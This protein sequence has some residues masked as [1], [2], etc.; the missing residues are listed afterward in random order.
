MVDDYVFECPHCEL[1]VTVPRNGLNCQIFRHGAYK[2][3]PSRQVPPH[4]PKDECDRLVAEGLIVGCGKPFRFD[5]KT[6]EKCGYV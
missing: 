5:G 3:D 6:V 4:T 2:A 1:L